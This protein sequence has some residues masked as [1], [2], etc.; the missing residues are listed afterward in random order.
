M[1]SS[2]EHQDD[3]PPPSVEEVS[4]G[5]FAYIQLDGSWGLNNTGFIV[6]R[7]AVVAIDCCFTERRTRWL[8]DASRRYA[9]MKP[10]RA[11]INTHHHG[12]HTHGNHLFLPEATIIGHTLCRETMLREGL[13]STRLWTD[14]EWGEIDVTPPF[15]T[16][17]DRLDIWVDDLKIEL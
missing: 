10:V 12:D 17:N 4:D 6:G 1:T 8:L 16:F 14:V 15:L 9:G 11:L 13:A 5:V 3:L 2:V 7:D